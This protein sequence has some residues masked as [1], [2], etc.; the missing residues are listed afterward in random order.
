MRV[1]GK[2]D[3]G[4]AIRLNELNIIMQNFAPQTE[5]QIREQQ[6]IEAKR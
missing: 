6:L 4:N 1:L 2:P 3:L 5:E